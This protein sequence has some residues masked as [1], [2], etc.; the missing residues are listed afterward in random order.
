MNICAINV[1]ILSKQRQGYI[2]ILNKIMATY[3]VINFN[4]TVV[5]IVAKTVYINTL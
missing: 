5:T 1:E 4:K 2:I 3:L